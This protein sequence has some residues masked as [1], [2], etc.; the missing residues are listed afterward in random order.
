MRKG[1]CFSRLKT[2]P[3]RIELREKCGLYVLI[4]DGPPEAWIYQFVAT[5]APL[6]KRVWS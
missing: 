5:I 6:S 4:D 3:P 1:S 2:F